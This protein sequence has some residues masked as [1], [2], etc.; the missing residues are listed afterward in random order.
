[1]LIT[2]VPSHDFKAFPAADLP[3]DSLH[4]GLEVF[5][6]QNLSAVFGCPNNVILTDVGTV[7][8]LI[9]SI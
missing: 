8:K 6:G 7:I 9:E 1:M 5:V 2:N 3:K 4:F